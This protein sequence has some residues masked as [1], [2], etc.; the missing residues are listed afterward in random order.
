MVAKNWISLKS[1]TYNVLT[2]S[3]QR[4]MAYDTVKKYSLH[5]IF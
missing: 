4:K 5:I 1:L 2:N 3:K